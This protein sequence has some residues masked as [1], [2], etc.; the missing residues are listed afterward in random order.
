[1]MIA[2]CLVLLNVLM[3][4]FT[5]SSFSDKKR[6]F[7]PLAE[8]V[9]VFLCLYSVTSAAL[10]YFEV[11]SV[12]FCLLAVMIIVTAVFV[13]A[14]FKSRKKETKFFAIGEINTDHG[15]I[16]NRIII[17]IATLL[18]LGAYSTF[19]IGNN[20]GNAQ[21]QALSII[22]GQGSLEFEIDEY[23]TIDP[24]SRYRNY[25]FERISNFDTDNFTANY[26][27]SSV[28]TQEGKVEKMIGEFGSDPVYP[29][30]LALSANLFG[31]KKMAFIQAVFAFCV[32]VFVDEIL[33]KL[34]CNW[35]LRSVLIMLL[36]TSPIIV[37]CNHTTL[38]EPIIGFC[39]VLFI[40]FLL[41]KKN[42]LQMLSVLGAVTFA[43]LHTSFYTMI[44]LFLALYWMHFV[45]TGKTRHL[46]SSGIMIIGYV[47][48]F[49]FLNAVASENTEINYKLGIPFLGDYY[50][51][52][53]IIISAAAVIVGL[54]LLIAIKKVATEKI[55]EF[56]K[57]KGKILFKI[58]MAVAS[59]AVIPV[60]VVIVITKCYTFQNF[61][62]ITIISFTVCTGVLL[63]PY[64]LFRLI[65]T[66]YNAGIKEASVVF[67]FV[68][69]VILYSCV[70]RVM[71]KGYYYETR[72]LSSFIPFV[73]I[74]AGMM[75]NLLKKEEK[76][77]IP[78]IGIIV[79]LTPYTTFLLNSDVE[80]RFDKEMLEDVTEIVSGNADKDTVVFI[81]KGLMKYLYFPVK[82]S[83][84][85]NVYPIETNYVEAF[86]KGMNDYESKVI[87]ITN[88]EGDKYIGRGKE[89]YINHNIQK[90]P[91][92][93]D[94]SALLGLPYKSIDRNCGKLQ[95]LEMDSLYYM[96]DYESLVSLGLSAVDLKVNDIE[97]DEKGIA[98]INVSLTEESRMYRNERFNLSYHLEYENAE[99][100]YDLPRTEIG[101][102][103]MKDYT[104]DVD[105]ANQPEDVT[106]VID[107]VE[108]GVQ[109]YSWKN[110]VPV[111]VFT[112]TDDSWNYEIY[113]FYTKL[114]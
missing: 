93:G 27:L 56:K 9:S 46:L 37:Y 39:M 29:S 86:C 104:L 83:T 36:G 114:K 35:K 90:R 8:A 92:R 52:F 1:M 84:D 54:I 4:F 99:D 14:Y 58:L 53:V 113:S 38:I 6:I 89:L 34:K 96:L 17:V 106:V 67:A 65:S 112:Q 16:I 15:I 20:D 12:E 101:P 23:E 43:F 66:R 98:H 47:L 70:M 64:I 82:Y 85:A 62:S 61:L 57:S 95:I 49:G 32:F 78:V 69:T 21:V 110:K 63:I 18:S 44:P 68:Y 10:W 45:H 40:Y 30:V 28:D 76:Y 74:L 105:L 71:L 75:L 25:F 80:T 48:S 22:N 111:I 33:R 59:A 91:F 26:W 79:L 60:T 108:E 24:E 11:F 107:I 7:V 103:V 41:C 87:Y 50:F 2:L 94:A 13:L 77:I 51:L 72:Y 3:L 5:F 19:G 42:K 31:I 109:W 97:I 88:N 73:I 81:E 100:I 55:A 102:L